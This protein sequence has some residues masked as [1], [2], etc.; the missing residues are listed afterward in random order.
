MTLTE[1]AETTKKAKYYIGI[2]LIAVLI[3]WMVVSMMMPQEDLPEKYVTPDYMCGQLD[4]FEL[5]SLGVATSDTKFT[6]ETTSG[7]IPDL[8]EVVNVFQYIH[9]PSLSA[10]DDA[11]TIAENLGFDPEGMLRKS[12]SEYQWRNSSKSQTLTIETG[13]LNF[14]LVTDF[15][16]GNINTYAERL[17]S[18]ENAKTIAMDYLR[19]VGLLTTDYQNGF[20]RAYLI[21]VTSSGEFR[22]APSISDAQLI[23]V[24]FFRQQALVTI[25]TEDEGIGGLGSTVGTELEKEKSTTITRDGES[26]EVKKYT[27]DIMN[28]SP[29]F[30]NITVFIGGTSEKNSSNYEIFGISYRNWILEENSCGTYKLITPQEAVR[31]VQEGEATL[32]YLLG[33]GEDKIVP[34]ESKSV[35]EMR[36]LEVGVSYLD[37]SIKQDYLQPIYF[38]KGE[39]QFS[40]GT[41]GEFYYYVPAVDYSS[42][43]ENAGTAPTTTPTE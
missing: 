35:T 36:I 19:D 5:R 43:P 16:G 18:E 31:R 24:D 28:D 41:Y 33:A 17:P 23:R 14:D 37:R 8:P 39:A 11:K 2:P 42:I 1:A 3:I 26:V 6:I 21:S 12:S 4:S 30:G 27:T 10:R 29:I 7:A 22:Q 13:N 34:P 32:V 40:N 20:Q 25:E 9:Q 38:I 15:T